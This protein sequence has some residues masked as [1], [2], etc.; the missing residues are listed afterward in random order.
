MS[1]F[2]A[3][4]WTNGARREENGVGDCKTSDSRKSV[5]NLGVTV[6]DEDNEV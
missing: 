6:A 3:F 2:R 1:P 5:S 4:F